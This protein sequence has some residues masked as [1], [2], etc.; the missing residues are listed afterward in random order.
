VGVVDGSLIAS[1]IWA[2]ELYRIWIWGH[3]DL[4]ISNAGDESVLMVSPHVVDGQQEP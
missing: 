1:I 3:I 4:K 2:G